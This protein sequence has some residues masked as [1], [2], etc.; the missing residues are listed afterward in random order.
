MEVNKLESQYLIG[1]RPVPATTFAIESAL[2][3]L[4]QHPTP[5]QGKVLFFYLYFD[6]I[7]LLRPVYSS[8]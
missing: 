4:S 6:S 2:V 3:A 7:L 5:I 8:L 1:W